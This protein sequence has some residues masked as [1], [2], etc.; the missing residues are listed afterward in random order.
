MQVSQLH[1]SMEVHQSMLFFL[2][3]LPIF[4]TNPNV[5]GVSTNYDENDKDIQEG[6]TK[7]FDVYH[8][9][10]STIILIQAVGDNAHQYNLL[11]ETMKIRQ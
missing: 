2:Q 1:P 11:Q 10:Q 3:K 6:T 7:T 5:A 4:L 8:N 9:P